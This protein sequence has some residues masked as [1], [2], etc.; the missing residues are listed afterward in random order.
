M[1]Q[2]SPLVQTG[3]G[4]AMRRLPPPPPCPAE[5]LQKRGERYLN[6]LGPRGLWPV[7]TGTAVPL[8]LVGATPQAGSRLCKGVERKDV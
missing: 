2:P 4:K 1:L 7:Q 5:P 6:G 3:Q 8:P